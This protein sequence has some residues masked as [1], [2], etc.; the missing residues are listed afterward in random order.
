MKLLFL[1]ITVLLLLVGVPGHTL[2]SSSRDNSP[3]LIFGLGP[4]ADVAR[5]SQ[6][7]QVSPFGMY[8]SWYN[9]PN[10]LNWMQYWENS[11]VPETYASGRAMH[12]IVWSGDEETGSPCGRQYPISSEINADMVRLAEIFGGKVSDPPLYVTL[13]T[14]FQTYPCTDNQWVGAEVYYQ[15]LQKK[16]IEIRDI[17]HE[18]APNSQV[19]IGWGG[20]QTRWDDPGN[21]GGRSL[22]GYFDATSRAM[23]FQS[24]QAMRTDS[25]VDDV[26]R[27]TKTLGKYGPV[28]LAHYKPDG[29]HLDAWQADMCSMMTD[30]FLEEVTGH[31][32]F[33]WSFM[34]DEE[35]SEDNSSS[36]SRMK[37]SL[38][39]YGE[40]P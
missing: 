27:M 20:W 35:M 19:S 3:A 18:H 6:I 26:R 1:G 16:M 23:D 31:G 39:R 9:G 11:L 34:D 8:T 33:A 25:N 37:C 15:R 24:F 28:M 40:T 5:D 7:N 21:G 36:Y 38:L 12:L 2:H 30:T 10:D 14:E 17:F 4:E 22:F 32:L 13:F 29:F